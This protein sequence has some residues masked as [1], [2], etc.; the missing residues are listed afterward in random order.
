MIKVLFTGGHFV[1]LEGL[2]D[3]IEP[4][5]ELIIEVK[6]VV[7]EPTPEEIEQAWKEIEESGGF[8]TDEEYERFQAWLNE[9]R[10]LGKEYT[11]ALWDFELRQA[12]S[13]RSTNPP[14]T[15]DH[16]ATPSAAG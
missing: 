5:S 2:P 15:P 10:R 3:D 6:E 16:P 14:T 9:S 11:R 4:E 8:L 7:R 12:A 13:A 1:P